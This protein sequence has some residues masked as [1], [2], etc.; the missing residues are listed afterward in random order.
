MFIE[1]S[2]R[3]AAFLLLDVHLRGPMCVCM[4]AYWLNPARCPYVSRPTPAH[5]CSRRLFW[6]QVMLL[7]SFF[8]AYCLSN[9]C[10]SCVY[11]S[12][13]GDLVWKCLE[14]NSPRVQTVSRIA[15][16]RGLGVHV[17]KMHR[18]VLVL[19]TCSAHGFLHMP[20]SEAHTRLELIDRDR[21]S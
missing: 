8:F 7:V 21:S 13:A 17:V 9:R 20:W 16:A 19:P 5:V 11:L 18:E 1:T 2:S 15:L 14:A 10:S 12:E 6:D 3:A 4:C